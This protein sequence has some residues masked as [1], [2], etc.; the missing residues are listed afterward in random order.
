[1]SCAILK[2]TMIN[3]STL[4]PLVHILMII[5]WEFF[6]ESLWSSWSI[7]EKN[8]NSGFIYTSYIVVGFSLTCCSQAQGPQKE[9][10][11]SASGKH[12]I[13]LDF[14]SEF[15]VLSK[16]SQMNPKNSGVSVFRK[17]KEIFGF[18]ELWVR[19]NSSR[20]W[21]R[22]L[23]LSFHWDLLPQAYMSIHKHPQTLENNGYA[24]NTWSMNS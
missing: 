17:K 7:I 13:V 5:L 18:K 19:G 11:L 10:L 6:L 9:G 4:Y 20:G 24:E 1:M 15:Y 8:P 23:R 21:R 22:L 12:L 14:N 2:C 16:F 3:L